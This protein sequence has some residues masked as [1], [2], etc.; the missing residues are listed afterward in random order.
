MTGVDLLLAAGALVDIANALQDVDHQRMTSTTVAT[1]D[2][3]LRET[4]RH[5]D[6]MTWT[7]MM[8][9]VDLLHP[10]LEAMV[11]LTDGTETPTLLDHAPHPADMDTV[12]ATVAMTTD[13]ISDAS[14]PS[15]L[16]MASMDSYVCGN[17]FP[18]WKIDLT[19]ICHGDFS[20]SITLG[21]S[22]SIL[23][24]LCRLYS[25]LDHGILLPRGIGS[26][27]F[28][29]AL[30]LCKAMSSGPGIGNAPSNVH[31]I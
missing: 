26:A 1:V 28:V 11:I 5:H 8:L 27:R 16:S 7:R 21:N 17:H 18:T 4:T 22:H 24:G 12:V 25:G 30:C 20:M 15:L 19:L 29:V 6:D 10:Q 31:K 2:A 14:T 13:A 23:F 3:P 9:R